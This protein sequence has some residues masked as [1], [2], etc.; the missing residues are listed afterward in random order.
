MYDDGCV[1]EVP[2]KYGGSSSEPSVRRKAYSPMVVDSCRE[3][4][5]AV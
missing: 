5:G 1:T 3:V 2:S 4:F